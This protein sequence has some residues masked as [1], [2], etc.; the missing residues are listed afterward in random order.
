MKA[1]L[2]Q[3][4]SC[5]SISLK[6]EDVSFSVEDGLNAKIPIL[7]SLSGNFAAG[8]L[9]AIMGPSGKFFN[10]WVFCLF[11]VQNIIISLMSHR[12]ILILT[13]LIGA[14]KTSLLNIL[15]GYR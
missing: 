12:L 2:S 4:P 14:G 10:S 11:L 13:F 8:K 3:L 1:K 9:I 15:A 5:P 7:R 6:F